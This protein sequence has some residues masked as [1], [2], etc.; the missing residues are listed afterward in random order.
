MCKGPVGW[1]EAGVCVRWYC[2][3]M[4]ASLW[5]TTQLFLP[6]V[7]DTH[8]SRGGVY[9]SSFWISV[10]FWLQQ[11]WYHMTSKTRFSIWSSWDLASMLWGSHAATWKF[12]SEDS[13]GKG[14]HPPD[15][16][17][18]KPLGGSSPGLWAAAADTECSRDELSPR[19]PAQIA[20]LWAK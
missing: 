5:D 4:P 14:H 16:W 19:G 20:Y 13:A 9:V 6:C 18:N 12:P 3:M 2:P 17:V 1:R 15:T 8:P 11:R 10:D 7:P